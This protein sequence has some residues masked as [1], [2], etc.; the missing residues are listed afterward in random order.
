MAKANILFLGG[1][2]M[3][4]AIVAGLVQNQYP[5][6]K[7]GV[8]DRNPEKCAHFQQAWGIRAETT[9]TPAL[10]AAKI[11]VLA[12][13][14]QDAA[15]ACNLIQAHCQAHSPLIIS[16]M[17]GI[18]VQNLAAALGQYLAI[19]RAMPNTPAAIQCGA[20]GLFAGPHCSDLDKNQAET[21]LRATGIVTWLEQ[22]DQLAAITALS[23]SGPAYYFYFMEIMSEVAIKMGIPTDTAR[24][25]AAQTAYGAAKLALEAPDFAKLRA[26][27][28]SKGG[29]TAAALASMQEHH[30]DQLIEKAMES[31]KNRALE[32]AKGLA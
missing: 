24:L 31:C 1:G 13:K 4:R 7:I 28:T 8:V 11:I 12:I 16:V 10:T 26:Q 2:N 21:I 17:A 22:E 30:L 19:V 18:T 27:V 23:G 29:S 25:F 20:T 9:L 5:V 3:T 15:P 32:L 6:E 14:P